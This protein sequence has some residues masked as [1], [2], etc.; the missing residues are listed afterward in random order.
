M[1]QPDQ[2][3]SAIPVMRLALGY[4]GV[5]VST[6]CCFALLLGMI[7]IVPALDGQLL[8]QSGI[9]WLAEGAVGGLL[10]AAIGFWRPD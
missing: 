10:L 6:I 5:V 3:H 8:H 7:G 2:P 1:T 9:R 4:I